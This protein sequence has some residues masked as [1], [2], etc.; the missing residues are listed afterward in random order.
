[1]ICLKLIIV[2]DYWFI[3]FVQLFFYAFDFGLDVGVKAALEGYDACDGAVLVE[4]LGPVLEVQVPGG[5]EQYQ[6]VQGQ[7][8]LNG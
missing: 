8:D 4:K 1:M 6:E 7:D 2:F 5:E 3:C